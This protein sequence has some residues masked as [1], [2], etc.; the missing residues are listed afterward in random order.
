MIPPHVNISG[1]TGVGKSTVS[2]I[3]AERYH[4]LW[5]PRV[6][7]RPRRQGENLNEYEFLT[8]E[9]F[10]QRRRPRAIGADAV[11]SDRTSDDVI[12]SSRDG[13]IGEV[14][15]SGGE[16]LLFTVKQVYVRKEFY[17]RGTQCP[18]K[19]PEPLPDTQLILSTFGYNS[20][21]IKQLV[22]PNMV[23][24]FIDVKDREEL[25][26]RL[27]ERCERKDQNFTEMWRENL[28]YMEKDLGQYHQHV[29]Y[30]DGTPEECAAEIEKLVGLRPAE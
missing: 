25:R 5:I 8:P 23:T 14:G 16:I 30:N 20:P 11:I 24:V 7:T 15:D 27:K 9:E 26:Q 13:S 2:L 28:K 12:I 1:Y 21:M 17:L 18:H 22:A 4:T 29:V 10:E 3:L 6:T 19:W